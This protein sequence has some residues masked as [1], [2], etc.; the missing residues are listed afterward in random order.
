LTLAIAQAFIGMRG[1][2]PAPKK[3]PCPLRKDALRS[4][5][6]NNFDFL[7]FALNVFKTEADSG[8]LLT[9]IRLDS[10]F[11]IRL[12]GFLHQIYTKS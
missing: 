12:W 7:A 9:A 1:L 6:L 11:L 8:F 2:E 10:F 4:A 3:A 5:R